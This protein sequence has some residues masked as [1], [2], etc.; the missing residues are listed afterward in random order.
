MLCKK[1]SNVR[2]L[3]ESFAQELKLSLRDDLKEEQGVFTCIVLKHGCLKMVHAGSGLTLALIPLLV[4]SQLKKHRCFNGRNRLKWECSY[5][6]GA[7]N[8]I[9]GA[10]NGSWTVC[11]PFDN[12]H[13]I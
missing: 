10:V 3:Q 11:Y 7:E 8:K 1:V 9:D 4:L 5:Y 12:Q 13:L 6:E 2:R